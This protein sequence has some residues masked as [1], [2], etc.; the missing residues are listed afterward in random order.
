MKFPMKSMP[1]SFLSMLTDW[2]LRSLLDLTRW[3]YFLSP[4][5]IKL[6]SFLMI[7]IP[8]HAD[9]GKPNIDML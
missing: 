1:Q 4:Q 5:L 2:E 8:V 9:F 7:Y 3:W 6:I